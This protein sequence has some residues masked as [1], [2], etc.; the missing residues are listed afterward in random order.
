[1][2]RAGRNDS[3]NAW[4]QSLGNAV[5]RYF[6]FTFDDFVYFFLQMGV[7]MDR[8]VC[9]ELVMR[10]CH[11]GRIEIAASPARQAFDNWQFVGINVWH[12]QSQSGADFNIKARLTLASTSASMNLEMASLAHRHHHH[13]HVAHVS[14]RPASS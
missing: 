3:N 14:A 1:M 10:E 9:V 4:N 6:Q 7:L 8:R 12:I 5:D 11:V 13:H 2:Q